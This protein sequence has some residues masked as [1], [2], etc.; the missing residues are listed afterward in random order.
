VTWK[1]QLCV[2]NPCSPAPTPEEYVADIQA[3][4]GSAA[5]RVLAEYPA[6]DYPN[7]REASAAVQGDSMFSCGALTLERTL[8]AHDIPVYAYEFVDPNP[9]STAPGVPLGPT[10]GT[11]LVY[12][13]Q[14][15]ASLIDATM[16]S[17]PQ[18]KLSDQMLSYWTNYARSADPN[19][20]GL[21]HWEP[22]TDANEQYLARTSEAPGPRLQH[23]FAD[24]H[25]C[26]F[27]ATVDP[28]M[29]SL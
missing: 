21:P 29:S 14:G 17:A 3:R 1:L 24:E 8:T 23:D 19:A 10:H 25:H 2:L 13:F 20:P 7:P 16:L 15:Q 18:L 9:P 27:W 11:E 22:F 26:D 28:I 4:F 5:D 6:V 12:V